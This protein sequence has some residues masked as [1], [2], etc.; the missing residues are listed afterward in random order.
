MQI[1]SAFVEAATLTWV[2]QMMGIECYIVFRDVR[3][4]IKDMRLQR[5]LRRV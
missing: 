3:Y 2:A 5:V 4:A 1:F